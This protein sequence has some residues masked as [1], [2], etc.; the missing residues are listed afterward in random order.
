MR[1]RRISQAI[2][3]NSNGIGA[4]CIFAI[5]I[6]RI[7]TSPLIAIVY[8]LRWLLSKRSSISTTLNCCGCIAGLYKLIAYW[9][10]VQSTLMSGYQYNI[11]SGLGWIWKTVKSRNTSQA[12]LLD[13]MLYRWSRKYGE[14]T[15]CGLLYSTAWADWLR[16]SYRLNFTVMYGTVYA[17]W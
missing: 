8:L 12:W 4:G 9:F 6:K 15:Y 11:F 7:I 10:Q 1:A 3:R 2:S 17:K 13:C 16:I 14:I 5:T